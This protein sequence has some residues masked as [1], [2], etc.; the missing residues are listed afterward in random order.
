VVRPTLGMAVWR[1]NLADWGRFAQII[2]A[3]T[4]E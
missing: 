3:E 2:I 1:K 4:L